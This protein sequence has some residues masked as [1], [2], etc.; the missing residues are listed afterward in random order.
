MNEPNDSNREG[1]DTDDAE[2]Q[3]STAF[4]GE[5]KTD[6]QTAAEH[7]SSHGRDPQD[8][9]EETLRKFGEFVKKTFREAS[10]GERL[11]AWINLVLIGIGIVG[12]VTY[13]RQLAAMQ[14]QLS[15]MQEQVESTDRPW[16]EITAA[17]ASH[18]VIF[19][20]AYEIGVHGNDYV[21]AGIKVTV[22]NVGRSVALDV[23]P[24]VELILVSMQIGALNNPITYPVRM[25]KKLCSEPTPVGLPIN[26][27]PGED[28]GDQSG[29]DHDIS[30]SGKTFILPNDPSVARIM[31]IF[32]GC[33]YY[34][35]GVSG[36]IHHSGFI[37][38]LRVVNPS[39][40]RDSGMLI[41]GNDIPIEDIRMERFA[42]GGFDAN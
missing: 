40:G 17:T 22:K 7:G 11:T 15:A 4:L 42:F 33:V 26:L 1:N 13:W 28:N 27:F 16:I 29:D 21:N 25:Q 41:V 20:R 18:P 3:P 37:Y 12:A 24:R 14:G 6:D 39:Q 35:I 36:K 30:L 2:A 31:P 38:Q 5:A 32:I 34:R 8:E 10:P 23:V 9:V 19:H